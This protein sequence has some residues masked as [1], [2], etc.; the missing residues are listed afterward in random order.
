MEHDGQ[1]FVSFW[2]IFWT[3]HL[4]TQKI[5]ILKKWTKCLEILSFC[6]FAPY[7]MYGSWDMERNGQNFLS[8]WSLFFLFTHLKNKNF[9][10]MK[11]TPGDITI[12]H[13]C[14]IHENQMMY[15]SWD[16]ERDGQN[17]LSFW[18]IFS[19]LTTRKIKIL[20]KWKMSGDIIVLH[21][22]TKN[23]DHMIISYNVPEIRH[24]TDLIYFSFWAICYS[25]KPLTIQ[26]FKI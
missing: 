20:K 23:H 26:K 3:P 2:T 12:L 19:T 16:M 7:I 11:K 22:C 25:F 24:W 6:I 8:F 5:K 9:E 14:T 1:N 21:T 13:T 4:T 15:G 10:R 17:S 18:I